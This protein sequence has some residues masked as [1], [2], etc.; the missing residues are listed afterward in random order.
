LKYEQTK[1]NALLKESKELTLDQIIEQVY[2]L[3]Q[4]YTDSE[5]RID[6]KKLRL[7]LREPPH[8]IFIG[9]NKAYDVKTLLEY[10]YREE[11]KGNT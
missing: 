3:K 4:Y 7:I 11:F 1:E 9:H 8:N 5:G 10:R 2:P 6:V